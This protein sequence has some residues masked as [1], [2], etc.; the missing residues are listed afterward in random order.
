MVKHKYSHKALKVL[1]VHDLIIL[2]NVKFGYKVMNNLLPYK[3]KSC[4]YT[5]AKGCSLKKTHRYNT[6]QKDTPNLP[7]AKTSKYL[8][9][10][11]CRGIKLYNELP[12]YTKMKKSLAGFCSVCKKT[13]LSN[14]T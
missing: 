7:K 4:T 2:E 14:C 1:P 5:D 11:F 10:V 8:M 6:R 13:Y 9:S 3:I 12:N